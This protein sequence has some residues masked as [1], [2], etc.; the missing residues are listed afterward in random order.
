M[1]TQL[2]DSAMAAI[3]K[4][5]DDARA[6]YFGRWRSVDSLLYQAVR[7]RG[8]RSLED[9]YTKVVLVN[10][11][12][13]AGI[14][15]ASR[16]EGD[17][18]AHVAEALMSMADGLETRLAS[19]AGRAFDRQMS[20]EILELHYY[21]AEGLLPSTGKRWLTSFVP[22]YLHFHCDQVPIFDDRAVTAVGHLMKSEAFARLGEDPA[23]LSG[24]VVA[25]RSFLTRFVAVYSSVQSSKNDASVTV[26]LVDH[27][28]WRYMDGEQNAFFGSAVND[29]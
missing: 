14:S 28:L 17:R 13:A 10:R 26:K 2:P 8:H 11:L 5:F 25:Y 3:A 22:K 18:E 20:A 6:D 1:E 16:A 4:Q 21:A 19:L 7:D 27:M 12:Y 24:G 9:V 29:F 23:R 15:R